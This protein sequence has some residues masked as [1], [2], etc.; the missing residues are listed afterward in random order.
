MRNDPTLLAGVEPGLRFASVL[1]GKG[2]CND[3]DWRGVA[4]WRPEDG[5]LWVHL[6]RDTEEAARW[7]TEVSGIDPLIA[8][9]LLAEDSRPRVESFGHALLMVLRGVNL[10]ERDEVELV[11]IHMWFDS[12]R[13][14]TL[15]DRD[16]ALSALRDIRLALTNRRGPRHASA[17]L[18]QIADKVVRDLEPVLDDLDA[19]ISRLEDA[20]IDPASQEQELRVSLIEIRRQAIHLRRY[21]GPQ[22]EALYRLQSEDTRLIDRRDRLRLRGV[23]DRVLR[24][25]EDLDAL[26]DRTAVLHEDMASLISEQIAKTSN[27]LTAVAALLLPPSLVAGM[28]GANIGGI[29]GQEDPHAFFEMMAV[30]IGLMALQWWVLRRIKWL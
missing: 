7:L 2:G 16:H 19:R 3:L 24:Y 8:E 17:L 18:L 21:L 27:R 22:R 26:R 25:L 23:I 28:L 13:A 1:D 5:Y 12:Q 14:I 20:V 6:E 10:A 4:A 29:P 11:P 30:M 9:A 15:R